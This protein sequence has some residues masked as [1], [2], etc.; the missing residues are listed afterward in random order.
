[1][2]KKFLFFFL[3]VSLL[4]SSQLIFVE[5]S[6]AAC[7]ESSP[8]VISQAAALASCEDEP[9]SYGIIIYNLYLCTAAPAAPTIA[10]S[11]DLTNCVETFSNSAGYFAS[12]SNGAAVNLS[13][14]A[15]LPPNG[16]YTHGIVKMDNTFALTASKQFEIAYNGQV[17]GTGVYCSTADGS[18]TVASGGVA[19][20]PT[21]TT[22]CGSS[23]VEAG[24]HTQTLTSMDDV[25]TATATGTNIAGTGANVTAYLVDA[26]Q[27][28]AANE[29]EVDKLNAVVEFA[30]AARITSST[31]NIDVSFNVGEG[32]Q[33][34]SGNLNGA[35]FFGIGPFQATITV[36]P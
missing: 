34:S 1:M 10:S 19:G 32:M 14:T 25:F 36:T 16:T 8:G 27:N 31:T 15:T 18:G 28:L 20:L 23:P 11:I 9:T 24:T 4:I 33:I 22:I 17:S 26:D 3:I 29:V 5:D 35:I 21:N 30:S 6:K 2:R 12:V 7:A 13:G